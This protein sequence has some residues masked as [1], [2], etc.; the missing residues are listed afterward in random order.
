MRRLV[1]GAVVLA[2]AAAACSGGDTEPGPV[3]TAAMADNST[4]TATLP[5]TA[6]AT[7]ITP[8]ETTT[9]TAP[10]PAPF[11]GTVSLML[12]IGPEAWES[13]FIDPG[14]VIY[15]DDLFHSFYNGVGEWPNHARWVMRPVL[16]ARRGRSNVRW[17]VQRRGPRLDWNQYLRPRRRGTRERHLGTVLLNDQ[18]EP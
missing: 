16:M 3:T 1:T 6:T 13:S 5:D 2:V 7:T 17:P 8:T 18:V 15:N 12:S 9:T 11:A 10:P 4:T 14:A